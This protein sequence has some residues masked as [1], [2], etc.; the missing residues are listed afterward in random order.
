MATTGSD[1]ATMWVVTRLRR[2]VTWLQQSDTATTGSDMGTQGVTWLQRGVMR[3][4]QGVTHTH[5]YTYKR[6][7]IK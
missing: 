7:Q 3:L 4:Q 5:I 1:M 6:T 2:G